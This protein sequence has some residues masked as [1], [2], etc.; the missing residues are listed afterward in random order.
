MVRLMSKHPLNIS[1]AQAVPYRADTHSA[2][3]MAY[4]LATLTIAGSLLFGCGG[5]K[6]QTSEKTYDLAIMNGRVMDPET[7]LDAVRNVGVLNGE[8]VSISQQPIKGAKVI[9]AAG[10]V[11]APGFIDMHAHDHS[12]FT[13]RLH[14]QDGV[15]SALELESGVF[16]VDKWYGSRIGGSTINFGA[17]VSHGLVR[18][19]AFGVMKEA[20]LTGD[21][22]QDE[23][24]A[25]R[26]IGWQNQNTTPEQRA[27]MDALIYKGLKQGAVGIGYHLAYTPGADHEEMLHF[28]EFS[29]K[30]KVPNFVHYRSI[31]QVTPLEG[32]REIIDGAE[33]TGAAI[34]AVHVNSSG[35]WQTREVLEL[36]EG[37]QKRGLDV[38]TE[39]YPYTG[40]H[41]NLH[42]P[43]ASKE[44]LARFKLD[45]SDLQ[46]VSTGERLTEKTYDYYKEHDASGE[47]IAHVM[48]QENIDLA[49][50]HPITS[51]G[52]DGGAYVDGKGHP[53]G[54]G[55]FSRIFR[56]YVRERQTLSL[57]DAVKK[58]SYMPAKR[59]ENFAPAM[60]RR[61]RI[62][63]GAIADITI[64][65]ANEIADQAT[66]A[67][68]A[69]PSKGIAY[70]IVNGKAV[71]SDY[72]FVEG[73]KPGQPIYGNK[74]EQP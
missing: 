27:Q 21:T 64:F 22:S 36:L 72:K 54:A 18:A 47:L 14:A 5:E 59:L 43:I 2:R 6:V 71:V 37:G 63:E 9:D 58:V 45:Y 41:A 15:T 52:S 19:I 24:V 48:K 11:V 30:E 10:L 31:G 49:V 61:G 23:N 68:G 55:T 60:K 62:Q 28:Y 65:N 7:G 20:E 8:I 67:D 16:P 12:D 53:R 57:M 51:I 4:R 29:A 25:A 26:Q 35:L 13:H 50:E 32:A 17:S 40:A 34:H 46:L 44:T 3:R 1:P 74:A 73:A 66:F 42:S 38:S 39:V 69:L 33:K 56:Q 70:V